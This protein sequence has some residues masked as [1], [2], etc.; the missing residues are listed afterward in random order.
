MQYIYI[1]IPMASYLDF[2]LLTWHCKYTRRLLNQLAFWSCQ[3]HSSD[4]KLRGKTTRTL[5][6]S[7][8]EISLVAPLMVTQTTYNLLTC[9]I[10][11]N[12]TPWG[13]PQITSAEPDH[14]S[15]F[16]SDAVWC[17]TLLLPWLTFS[18]R[19]DVYQ[20]FAFQRQIRRP[21]KVHKWCEKF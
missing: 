10:L 14:S 1:Y 11:T 8:A 20:E 6:G 17:L 3:K 7:L 9:G 21:F 5:E 16:A 18:L 12:M 13:K 15:V 2:E 19:D 4:L